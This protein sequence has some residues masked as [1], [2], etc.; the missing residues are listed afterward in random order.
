MNFILELKRLFKSEKVGL[1]EL[2]NFVIENNPQNNYLANS[3]E[4]INWICNEIQAGTKMSDLVNQYENETYTDYWQVDFSLGN[5]QKLIP[6][7][8]KSDLFY[9][10]T[11]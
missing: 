11:K 3:E 5:Q 4:L 8:S 10:I 7:R 2:Y 6:I 1:D 9:Y